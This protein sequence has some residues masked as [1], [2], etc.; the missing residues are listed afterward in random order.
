MEFTG[1]SAHSG[2]VKAKVCIVHNEDEFD[3]CSDGD[4]VVLVAVKPSVALVKLSGAL[5]SIHGG[6]TSHAAIAARENDKPTVV[7]LKEE[8]LDH[9]KDGDVVE[10]NASEGIIIL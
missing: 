6:I 2:L 3:H 4:V 1:I 9:T 8:L 5:I 7:G 10:V